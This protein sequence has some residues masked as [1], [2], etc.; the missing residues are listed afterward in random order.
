MHWCTRSELALKPSPRAH[1]RGAL[2][3]P[4]AVMLTGIFLLL[5]PLAVGL[6][7]PLWWT[8]AAALIIVSGAVAELHAVWTFCRPNT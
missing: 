4:G 2:I 8:R 6:A 5:G 7:T 3:V 1:L